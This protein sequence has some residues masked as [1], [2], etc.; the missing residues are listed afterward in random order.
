MSPCSYGG[1]RYK[2]FITIKGFERW[3]LTPTLMNRSYCHLCH[4][5]GS[6]GSFDP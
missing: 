4:D 5:M 2:T 3:K 1:A 6:S